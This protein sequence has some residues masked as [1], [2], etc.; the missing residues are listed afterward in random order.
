MLVPKLPTLFRNPAHRQFDYKPIYYDER[1]ERIEQ[2]K[3]LNQDKPSGSRSGKIKFH[4]TRGKSYLYSN[5][6]LIAIIFALL[7]LAYLIIIF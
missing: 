5:L 6:R 3:G 1:K 4:S 2:L 7:L